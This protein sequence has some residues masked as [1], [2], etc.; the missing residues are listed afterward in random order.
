MIGARR[1]AAYPRQT[2]V[3]GGFGTPNLV[4]DRLIVQIRIVIVDRQADLIGGQ[5]YG[6][7][8]RLPSGFLQQERAAGRLQIPYS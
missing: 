6:L 4:P 8:V 7:R 2:S 5:F 3:D 1:E